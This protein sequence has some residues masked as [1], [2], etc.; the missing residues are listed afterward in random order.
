MDEQLANLSDDEQHASEEEK[1]EKSKV[2]PPP[3][4]AAAP[5][6]EHEEEE[7]ENDD[8]SGNV[9]KEGTLELAFQTEILTDARLPNQQPNRT[10]FVMIRTGRYTSCMQFYDILERQLL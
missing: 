7:S 4:A 5:Q 8:Q 10:N 6:P 1:K 3:A 2:T 9:G